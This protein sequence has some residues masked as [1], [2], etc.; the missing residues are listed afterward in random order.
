MKRNAIILAAGKGTRMRSK[1]YK[2]LH[3]VCGKTMV[4]H[5]VGQ[6][7]KADIDNIVTVVGFGAEKV[8]EVIGNRTKFA[9]QNQQLGTGHAVMQ[10]KD[11]LADN[12]GETVVVSGDT[13]L[14]TADTFKKLFEYHEQR[15]AAATILTSVAPDP[16]GYGRI[17]RDEVGIV[18][19]IV[20]QKDATLTEQSIH[21]IN[22]G[23]YCFDNKKLF[24]A[25]KEVNN[26]NA[27]GEYYLT[28]VI[29]I[30][31]NKQE[32]VTA[33]KMAD[34]D[35]SMGVNDRV[36]L[37]RANKIMRKRINTKLM[38]SG[39]TMVNP[40]TTYIDDGVKIGQDTVIEGGVVIKGN[41]TIGSDCYI[42]AH[43]R[44]EDSTIHD[45]VTIT[46]STLQEAEMHDGSDI[47]PNSHLR[48]DAEVGKNV[49][50]G[51]FCEVKKAFIGEG[52]KVGHLTYIGNATLGKN[53]NVGCGVVFVNYDGKNKHHTNVGD[54]AFIG[55]NSNLVAPV[56]LAANAFVAAGSTITDNVEE[57]DMAIARARQVNKEAYA[58]KLPW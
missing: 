17:V 7:E 31:K 21:E 46:S 39:V 56:N 25:L 14:F 26:N 27:Q 11:L 58:K 30:L 55:S 28:D 20:E 19:R 18:E 54:H 52:T 57:Y 43:S 15:H 44:I 1:L 53:I 50:I 45:G 40:E 29:E 16:T 49:H 33:Y 2:V 22:T 51:N 4:E 13:P 34:F 48:P 41:T 32:I 24:A 38:E 42:S 37:A 6:L 3:E 5:V 12:D 10:A 23:V 47:G 8:E 36:A 9:L 35:E